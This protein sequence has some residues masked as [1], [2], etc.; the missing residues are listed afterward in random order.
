MMKDNIKGSLVFS[1]VGDSLGWITE[2]L[3]NPEE[4]Q[5]RHNINKITSFTGWSKKVGGPYYG[6][7]DNIKE[8]SYSDD[9]QLMLCMLRSIRGDGLDMEYFAKSELANWITYSRG[10]GATIKNA[11]RKVKRKKIRWNNNFF[12]FKAG[13]NTIDSRASGANGAAMRILPIALFYKDEDTMLKDIFLNSIITHGH[14]TAIIG[15]LL[16][17]LAVVEIKEYKLSE[18][19][20]EKFLEKIGLKFKSKVEFL[21][22]D[23][24]FNDLDIKSW[25]EEWDNKLT[26]PTLKNFNEEYHK[27]YILCLEQLRLLYKSLTV[28]ESPSVV[29]DNIGCFDKDT[30]GSGIGTVL[31]GIYLFLLNYKSPDSGIIEC[32][33]MFGSD[34]DSIAAFCGGLTG[35]LHGYKSFPKKF[36]KLQ[37]IEYMLT[38]SDNII[39]KKYFNPKSNANKNI[40]INFI[41]NDNL[42]I[43]DIVYFYPLGD[44]E[45][46]HIERQDTLVEG[47][48]NL[49]MHVNFDIGQSCVFSKVFNK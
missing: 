1:A 35:Y 41:E 8:G 39:D 46:T 43:N 5:K 40:S 44:G 2:F 22:D 24:T 9:T 18:F 33:N 45:I 10:A 7:L 49:I 38:V 27:S 13:K 32:S 30:K 12:N 6:F 25:I 28:N 16:Y 47:K 14:P 23:D 29:L 19:N 4:L 42:N 3:N 48:Y 34:T 26:I 15:A 21:L 31:A 17:A 20:P 36:K 11:A 37:D